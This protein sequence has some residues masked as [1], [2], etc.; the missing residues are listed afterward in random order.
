MTR[1]SSQQLISVSFHIFISCFPVM[2]AKS[3]RE[4][5]YMHLCLYM[6]FSSSLF[7]ELLL[8]NKIS[9]K[10]SLVACPTLPVSERV[11]SLS[12]SFARSLFLCEHTEFTS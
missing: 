5:E 3:V 1:R 4:R 6:C 7:N 2:I 9:V 11:C 10:C 8:Q 12:L